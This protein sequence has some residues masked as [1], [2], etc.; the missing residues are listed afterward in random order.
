M[1]S[2]NTWPIERLLRPI[3]RKKS[4]VGNSVY[5]DKQDFPITQVLEDNYAIIKS[6]LEPLMRR[7]VDFAPF[8][9]I[10]PDQTFIS[11]DDKWKMFFLKAG[12]VRFKK[13]CAQVPKT[14]A[15]LDRHRNVVSAYFSVLGPHKMLMP[16]EGPWCGIIRIHLGLII[17]K[18][19][20]GCV[21]VCGEQEYRWEEG[22]TV[23]FDDTY[24]HIAVNM[25]DSD[26]VVLFLD[27][28]RPL[29][30]PWSWLNWLVVK[31]ARF[32]PY[33]RIPIKRHKAWEQKF[34]AQ[35][36]A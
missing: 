18:G 8:Q 20:T 2:F 3:F 25:T 17:P 21:L 19:G 15:I 7:A 29:P 36:E 14:M 30:W 28:M 32:L 33:F 31:G 23:V 22:K 24:E 27:Y 4:L 26:R 11:N 35:G 16:H 6:E 9:D 12:T 10:S 34:Y 1:I 5:F 13:N